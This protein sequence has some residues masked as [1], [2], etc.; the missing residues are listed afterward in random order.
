VVSSGRMNSRQQRREV[1]LR[2]LSGLFRWPLALFSRPSGTGLIAAAPPSTEAAGLDSSRPSGTGT[3]PDLPD[4][5]LSGPV[6]V[7]R[8]RALVAVVSTARRWKCGFG[9]PRRARSGFTL[10]EVLVAA[11]VL[12]I[13]ISAG[14]RA[15][16]AMVQASAAAADRETAVRLAGER[17]ARLEGVDG[18]STGDAQGDFEAEPRFH[19]QQR[20][21]AASETGVLEATV[22]ITWHDASLE[23]RY[24]V[25]TYVLDPSQMPAS[26][27]G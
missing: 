8:L 14:V 17:L 22:T 21:A 19:W 7:G 23:R 12:A 24:A 9:T 18:V 26:Q 13:G 1:R 20:A 16:G 4:R 15:M 2:G 3:G 5:P 25:T 10:I 6:G 11:V 27:G